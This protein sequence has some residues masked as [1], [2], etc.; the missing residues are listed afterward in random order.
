MQNRFKLPFGGKFVITGDFRQTLPVVPHAGR[1][2]IIRASLKKS[3]LWPLFRIF[4]LTVV[5]MRVRL[6]GCNPKAEEYA[7]WL[8][9]VGNGVVDIGGENKKDAQ[10]NSLVDIPPELR[11]DGGVTALIDFV[12]PGLA[13]GDL[14]DI[15]CG[16]IM[17]EKQ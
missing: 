2:Q 17:C 9:N 16:S 6:N 7:R 12:F 14:S 4:K 10:G 5:N 1:A 3:P 13:T 8:L 15:E 11:I